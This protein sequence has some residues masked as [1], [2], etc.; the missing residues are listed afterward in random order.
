MVSFIEKVREIIENLKNYVSSLKAGIVKTVSNVSSLST[1]LNNDCI[2]KVKKI[3]LR[4]MLY[5]IKEITRVLEIY[6]YWSIK[7]ILV[8][9]LCINLL[10]K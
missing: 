9:V 2:D 3:I 10:Q 8:D 5:N 7:H 1:F 4:T 6:Y